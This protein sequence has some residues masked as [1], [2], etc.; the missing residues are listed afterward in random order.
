M[1][2][3]L[4]PDLHGCV[5]RYNRCGL[6]VAIRAEEVASRIQPKFAFAAGSRA[7][8]PEIENLTLCLLAQLEI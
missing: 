6:G 5:L 3:S 4:S 7:T 2:T 8:T 1:H